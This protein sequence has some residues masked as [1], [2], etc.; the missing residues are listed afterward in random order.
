MKN[1]NYIIENFKK[2]DLFEKIDENKLN[3]LKNYDT[4]YSLRFDSFGMRIF[5]Y[6][7][8]L[9]IAKKLEKKVFILWDTAKSTPTAQ[10]HKHEY[11]DHLVF[12][13]LPIRYFNSDKEFIN[14]YEKNILGI[15]GKI[16]Y[17]ENENLKEVLKELSELAKN[18]ELNDELKQKIKNIPEYEYG[19][20]VRTG[21]ITAITANEG[22]GN[23]YW[24]SRFYI[25]YKK[26]F[27][28]SLAL[29]IIKKINGSSTYI[30]SSSEKFLKDVSN[31]KNIFINLNNF[32]ENKNITAKKLIIDIYTLSKCKNLICTQRSGVAILAT[33]LS[34]EN[35]IS[36]EDFLDI[37][38]IYDDLFTVINNQLTE[39][40]SPGKLL[41]KLILLYFTRYYYELFQVKFKN[42]FKKKVKI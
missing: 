10:L 28:E 24:F 26:W 37:G 31:L 21:D 8:C 18:L 7:N 6:L 39:S 1:I 42:F 32:Q 16:L 5:A 13:N 29:N 11:D 25:G 2:T 23:Y 34:N 40:N 38:Q 36:P 30:A 35:V 9:R 27:P 33:L 20:H 4:L 3:S 15:T 12:K 14:R 19:I 41:K 17:L 22:K